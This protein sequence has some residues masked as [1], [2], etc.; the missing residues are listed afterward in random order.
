MR[1]IIRSSSFL[2]LTCCGWIGLIGMSPAQNDDSYS[3]INR[4]LSQN[5]NIYSNALVEAVTEVIRA[6]PPAGIDPAFFDQYE[7]RRIAMIGNMTSMKLQEATLCSLTNMQLG[8]EAE[9][10]VLARRVEEGNCSN[11]SGCAKIVVHP[12]L[13][14]G[15]AQKTSI[16]R[17]L[18]TPCVTP[19]SSRRY[20]N[21][22]G[23]GKPM[24][25]VGCIR[26]FS[27]ASS[28]YEIAFAPGRCAKDGD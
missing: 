10:C 9:P 19:L 21:I 15:R 14:S 28:T 16:E 12:S 22:L 8:V 17:S 6:Q 3:F 1:Q 20:R 4:A 11:L 23:C 26:S 18:Q 5:T 13:L 25:F 24:E 27:E 7:A 2:A